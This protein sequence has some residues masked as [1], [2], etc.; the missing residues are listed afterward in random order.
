MYGDQT[1]LLLAF[2]NIWSIQIKYKWCA[3][4]LNPVG[5]DENKILQEKM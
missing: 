4:D 1:V 5:T 3:W 2:P